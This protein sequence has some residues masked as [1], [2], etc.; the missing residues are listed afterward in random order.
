MGPTLFCV[1]SGVRLSAFFYSLGVDVY[2]TNDQ[3]V[4]GNVCLCVTLPVRME[5]LPIC[6]CGL[7]WHAPKGIGRELIDG[8]AIN[9]VFRS[10]FTDKSSFG[11]FSL[12]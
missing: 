2:T 9:Y 6:T 10:Y 8:N 11:G 4:V 3:T 7:Y 5:A 12:S 1:M